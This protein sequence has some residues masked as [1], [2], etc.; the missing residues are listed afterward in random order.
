V[1]SVAGLPM[2]ALLPAGEVETAWKIQ[3]RVANPPRLLLKSCP[4]PGETR[5]VFLIFLPFM[6]FAVPFL[7]P[8]YVGRMYE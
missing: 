2:T 8:A 1:A 6:L 4:N 3:N 7:I 5:V